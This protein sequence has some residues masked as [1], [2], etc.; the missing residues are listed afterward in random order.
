MVA[1]NDN[2]RRTLLTNYH[3]ERRNVAEDLTPSLSHIKESN[4]ASDSWRTVLLRSAL[5]T[6]P[7]NNQLCAGLSACFQ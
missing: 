5:L 6:T 7:L 3:A 2:Y 1:S 4:W